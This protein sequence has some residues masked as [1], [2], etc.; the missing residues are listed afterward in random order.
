TRYRLRLITSFTS[1]WLSTPR[2]K[3]SSMGERVLILGAGEGGQIASWLLQR[4]GL[5]QA[6]S[7]VGMVDDDPALQ[8]MRVG[9]C[10]VLG[11][12]GDLPALVQQYDVG[13]ILISVT[14]L[15]PET[16]Q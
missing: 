5:Q 9:G 6:I 15:I 8:G 11:G 2:G 7:I 13:I 3:I 14:N 10:W 1:R 4:G 12:T 16:M